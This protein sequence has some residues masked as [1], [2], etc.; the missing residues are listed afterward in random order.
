MPTFHQACLLLSAFRLDSNRALSAGMIVIEIA[1]D[2]M[3]AKI[4]LTD[5]EPMKSPEPPSSN[6][7][8]INAKMVVRVDANS[9]ENRCFTD[10]SIA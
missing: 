9:G 1:N 4:T 6:N 3:S 5:I 2:D 7:I 10:S 8:G